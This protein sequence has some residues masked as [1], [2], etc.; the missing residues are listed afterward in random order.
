[1]PAIKSLF[2]YVCCVSLFLSNNLPS[3]YKFRGVEK[4][5]VTIKKPNKKCTK[6]AITLRLTTISSEKATASTHQQQG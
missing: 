6:R 1:M 2:D 5:F 4:E 3:E